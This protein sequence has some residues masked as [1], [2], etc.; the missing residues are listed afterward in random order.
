[1][2]VKPESDLKDGIMKLIEWTSGA[3]PKSLTLIPFP[4]N[5]DGINM[6]PDFSFSRDPLCTG[7]PYSPAT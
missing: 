3:C 1:M 5:I 2:H 7:G 6:A 4:P